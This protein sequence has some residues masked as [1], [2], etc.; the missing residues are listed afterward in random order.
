STDHHWGPRL[1]LFLS[2]EDHA[3]LAHAV[4][5]MLAARLPP[6]FRGYPTNFGPP[7]GDGVR[8]LE[9][10]A[11]GPVS[12]RVDVLT[13][14]GFMTA[15][16]G[17][18]PREGV[19]LEDWLLTPTQAL[20]SVTAGAVYHDG[21]AELEPVR[22]LLRWYPHDVWLYLIACGWTRISQEEAF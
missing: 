3:H 19:T 17:F 12:H 4:A 13:V 18:D 14:G 10:V 16:L 11:R 2:D 6:A 5:K 7:D 9:P 22:S 21:L 15:Q 1:L 8:H 20:L